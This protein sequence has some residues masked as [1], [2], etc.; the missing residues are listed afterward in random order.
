MENVP[1]MKS[2]TLCWVIVDF[3][4]SMRVKVLPTQA[5]ILTESKFTLL[6]TIAL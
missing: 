3:S 5:S 6:S 4:A 1:E 2:I